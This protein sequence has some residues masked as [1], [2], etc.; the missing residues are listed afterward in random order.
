M[1]A[2][3]SRGLVDPTGRAQWAIGFATPDGELLVR[4][5]TRCRVSDGGSCH[6]SRVAE[7][8]IADAGVAFEIADVNRDGLPEAIISSS[9]APG[10][11]DRATVLTL[12]GTRADKLFRRKFSGGIV[13]LAAADLDGNGDLEVVAA[14]R[15]LGSHRVDVWTLN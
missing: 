1:R 7:V 14:V 15:L 13:G 12:H 5:H 6:G 9:G 10:D 8:G 3:W 2:G 4:L 11:P